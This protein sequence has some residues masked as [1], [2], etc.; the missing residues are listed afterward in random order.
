MVAVTFGVARV[1]APAAAETEA[2]KTRKNLF[3]RVFDAIAT[4]Q[5]KRA[6][7]DLARY[8]HLLPHDFDVHAR[9]WSR[10]ENGPIGG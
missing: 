7:R 3:V 5:M 6:E 2:G 9:L 1:A 8:R 10:D 4:S